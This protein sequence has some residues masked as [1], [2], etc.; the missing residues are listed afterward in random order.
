MRAFKG[1]NKHEDGTLWCMDF[2]YEVGKTYK[3]NGK[4]KLCESGFHA[5]HE[6]HYVWQFY[7]NNGNNVFYE[8]ECGGD[9]VESQYDDGKI[10]CSEITLTNEIDTSDIEKFDSLCQFIDGLAIAFK[11]YKSFESQK[12]KHNYIKTNGKALSRRW[13]DSVYPFAGGNAIVRI[14]NKFN[15]IDTNGKILSDIW[16]DNVGESR[17]GLRMVKYRYKYN[18]IKVN[19]EL[20]SEQWFDHVLYYDCISPMALINGEWYQINTK[21]ELIKSK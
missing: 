15:L 8:V 20:L 3:H 2:Q 10:V 14:D 4:I 9:I 21:G 11:S 1:F 12:F 19:G 16:F 17:N 5:C 13:F 7:P 6:L 18:F